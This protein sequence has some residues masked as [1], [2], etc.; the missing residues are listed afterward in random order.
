MQYAGHLLRE[1]YSAAIGYF[2]PTKTL[3][4]FSVLNMRSKSWKVVSS[5]SFCV[6]LNLSITTL[7]QPV[8]LTSVIKAV[9]CVIMPLHVQKGLKDIFIQILSLMFSV[10]YKCYKQFNHTFYYNKAFHIWKRKVQNI[11]CYQFTWYLRFTD[12]LQLV[13]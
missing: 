1:S 7:L 8:L 9:S 13:C 6:S 3:Q 11:P 10:R 2:H 12:L 4:Y 5:S